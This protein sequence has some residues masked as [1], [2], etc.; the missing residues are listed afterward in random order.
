MTTN[1]QIESLQDDRLQYVIELCYI[2]NLEV[3]EDGGCSI[4]DWANCFRVR[5][6]NKKIKHHF[7]FEQFLTNKEVIDTIQGYNLDIEKFWYALLFIYDLTISK[8]IN[9][10]EYNKSIYSD[11][12][13]LQSYLDNHANTKLLF[14]ED[15]KDAKECFSNGYSTA[16]PSL[17]NLIK[18]F[19]NR[20]LSDIEEHPEQRD[21]IETSFY[22][23]YTRSLSNSYQIILFYKTFRTL[24]EALKLPHKKKKSGEVTNYNK[25]LLISR[26][27][28][29]CGLTVNESYLTDEAT[30]N[31]IIKQYEQYPF[32][33]QSKVY[34]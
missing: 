30:L 25:K 21:W 15:Y 19:V 23:G 24:F 8:T 27:I 16:S 4:G 3:Y 5:Y 17:I 2:I 13:A 12:T 28:Y 32:M 6:N 22:H 7:T 34:L 31:G 33:E 18:G 11:M 26:L 20:V 9:I 10:A 14:Y 29:F 1:Q